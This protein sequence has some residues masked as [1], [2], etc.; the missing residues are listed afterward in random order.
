MP[1]RLTIEPVDL[2]DGSPGRLYTLRCAHGESWLRAGE[3]FWGRTNFT[4][5]TVGWLCWRIR[6]EQG[7]ACTGEIEAG[8]GIR[9]T[10]W[11]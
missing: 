1:A 5:K 4:P 9:L 10:D 3:A 2:D 6:A 7:C 11:P 8:Y